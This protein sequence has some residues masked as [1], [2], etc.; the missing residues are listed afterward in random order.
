MGKRQAMSQNNFTFGFRH[1]LR[2]FGWVMIAGALSILL[3]ELGHCIFYW[4]QGVPAAMSLV[5]E[6]P[7]RDIT[8]AQYSIGSA[9]GPLAN[10]IQISVAYFLFEKQERGTKMWRFLSGLIFANVFY[11]IIR[12]L[13]TIL[14]NKGGEL[15]SAARMIGLNFY[16]VIA[17][18]IVLT[19]VFL[20]L[21]VRHSGT[22]VTFRNFAYFLW[23]FL[24]F[25]VFVS[26]LHNLD[27]A[28]FWKRFPTIHIDDGRVYNQKN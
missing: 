17:F 25:V 10:I 13:E 22:A 7:L 5:K 15:E 8:A 1:G 18:Y 12:S 4:I 3:H 19:V 20:T 9:G 2:F 23:L 16:F 27:R 21:W 6:Y 14:K 28:L 24:G 26:T 11:F